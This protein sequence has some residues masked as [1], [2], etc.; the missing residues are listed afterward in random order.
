MKMIFV[1]DSLLRTIAIYAFAGIVLG[2]AELPSGIIEQI[3]AGRTGEEL[4]TQPE[5]LERPTQKN[6]IKIPKAKHSIPKVEAARI[7]FTLKGVVIEGNTV[8]TQKQ[9][10]KFY[11][12][13]IGQQISVLDLQKIADSITDYYRENGYILSQ[14]II[15]PQEVDNGI[16]TLQ[17]VEGYVDQFS[18]EGV[19]AKASKKLLTKYGNKILRSRPLKFK[20]LERF[21]LLANDIPGLSVRT[22][23]TTSKTTPGAAHLTFISSEKIYSFNIGANNFNSKLLGRNSANAGLYAYAILP[24]SETFIRGI[25]SF[26]VNKLLYYSFF[27][28]QSL[29]DNGATI[30]GSISD[31]KT[32]PTFSSLG[33]E[34]TNTPGDSFLILGDIYYPFIRSR[35]KNFNGGIGFSYMNSYT[36]LATFRLFNDHIRAVN[37]KFA[38]DFLDNF[39]RAKFEASIKKSPLSEIRGISRSANNIACF[40]SELFLGR[41]KVS[42]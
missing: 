12:D 6:I 18:I 1:R 8:F 15:P 37:V 16:V 29:N 11:K 34:D 24:G 22:V 7:K 20:Q 39:S 2:A 32:K 38:Y 31:T 42:T 19:K 17:V 27:H 10:E 5:I 25:S 41:F 9:L 26:E 36:D 4:T 23:L 33:I 13:K 30:S 40:F 21:A 3:D 14:V 28:Q 35:S